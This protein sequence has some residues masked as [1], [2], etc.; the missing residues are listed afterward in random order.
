M[1]KLFIRMIVAVFVVL[2][3]WAVANY[4]LGWQKPAAWW[5]SLYVFVV[6]LTYVFDLLGKAG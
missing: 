1:S 2:G 5:L 6:P 4:L 3:E